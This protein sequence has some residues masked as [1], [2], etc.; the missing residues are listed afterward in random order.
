[1]PVPAPHRTPM[2]AFGRAAQYVRTASSSDLAS[3]N[4][5][6]HAGAFWPE[7]QGNTSQPMRARR[8]A[9]VPSALRPLDETSAKV[10]WWYSARSI[11]A[12]PSS[13][14]RASR[15]M[16]SAST[17]SCSWRPVAIRLPYWPA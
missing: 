17:L 3:S 7:R 10:C 4:P 9:R 11:M 2:L 14:W 15:K 6:R 1:M 12:R 13:T 16:N 5:L 8:T